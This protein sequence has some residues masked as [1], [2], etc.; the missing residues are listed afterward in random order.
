MGPLLP[1]WK[2]SLHLFWFYLR[3]VDIFF[4]FHD[5]SFIAFSFFFYLSNRIP[6][7]TLIREFLTVFVTCFYFYRFS[8]DRYLS[9]QTE[10]W[11]LSL[12]SSGTNIFTV[13]RAKTFHIETSKNHIVIYTLYIRFNHIYHLCILHFAVL[14]TSVAEIKN[15]LV[16]NFEQQ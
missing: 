1:S 6:Q 10:S 14:A 13:T 11:Y 15:S 5:D 9:S 3:C 16:C 4:Y 7:R 8:T 12:H 2:V